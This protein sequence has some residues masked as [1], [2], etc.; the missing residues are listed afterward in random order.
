MTNPPSPANPADPAKVWLLF[1]TIVLCI[2][3][4]EGFLG[5][6]GTYD[7]A[8][9]AVAV[10]ERWIY[11]ATFVLAVVGVALVAR[12]FDRRFRRPRRARGLPH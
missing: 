7:P 10:R 11:G 5:F 1:A 3:A 2:V 4:V 6:L 9:A 12:A 8:E